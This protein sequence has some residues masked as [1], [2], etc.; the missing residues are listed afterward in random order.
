MSFTFDRKKVRELWT[1]ERSNADIAAE[2]GLSLLQLYAA[3][4][5]L[6]LRDR[7]V[8]VNRAYEKSADPTPEEIAERCAE[9][10]AEWPAGEED[11]RFVGSVAAPKW[12]IPAFTF[13]RRRHYIR[14]Q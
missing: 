14:E 1:T 12:T 2:L 8:Y 4:R 9:I 10:R 3:G 7:S 13:D 11:R 6:K 5:K